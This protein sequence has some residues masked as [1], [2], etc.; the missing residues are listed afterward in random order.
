MILVDFSSVSA[1]ALTCVIVMMRVL[2]GAI[3]CWLNRSAPNVEKVS[4][5]VEG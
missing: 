5:R 4:D 1:I 2:C 3:A